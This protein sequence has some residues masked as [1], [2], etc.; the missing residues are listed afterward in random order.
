MDRPYDE[1]NIKAAVEEKLK[2]TAKTGTQQA[3]YGP[4]ECKVPAEVAAKDQ[5]LIWIDDVERSL[6]LQLHRLQQAKDSVRSA[7]NR[8]CRIV[9]EILNVDA[10]RRF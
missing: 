3:G 6:I 4:D 2:A 8:T 1:A 10:A 7:S 5:L 9:R